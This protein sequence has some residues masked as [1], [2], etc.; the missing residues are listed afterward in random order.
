MKCL[1]RLVTVCLT[2]TFT[3]SCGAASGGLSSPELQSGGGNSR[4]RIANH[5]VP[6]YI[7]V[8]P[9]G[10]NYAT[11]RAQ[12][13]A[14]E[15]IPFYSGSVKSPLDGNTYSYEIVGKNPATPP[16]QET[17]ILFV[18]IVLVLKFPEGTLDPT[19]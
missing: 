16:A 3:A 15:T 17:D 12:A 2:A 10:I 11:L 14:G 5:F 7:T 18:P 6:H 8:K 1:Y 19:Q 13:K 9:S 4:G